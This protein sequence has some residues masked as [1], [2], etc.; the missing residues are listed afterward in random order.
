MRR[1]I[2]NRLTLCAELQV[3]LKVEHNVAGQ[4]S[5]CRTGCRCLHIY[6]PAYHA[7]AI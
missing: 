7:R 5:Q 2:L 6:S 3:G 1:L 4:R